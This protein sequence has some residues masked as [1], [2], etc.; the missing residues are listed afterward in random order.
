MIFGSSQLAAVSVFEHL[1]GS[2][3]LGLLHVALG[4]YVI[5]VGTGADRE[6]NQVGYR[7]TSEATNVRR[8]WGADHPVRS[9]VSNPE[10]WNLSRIP[11]QRCV[12]VHLITAAT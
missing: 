10:P 1:L 5:A 3:G 11:E 4:A 6:T 9:V 2:A 8:G 12:D 7:G